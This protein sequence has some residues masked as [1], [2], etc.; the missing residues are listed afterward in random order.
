MT[1]TYLLCKTVQKLP[2]VS[3]SDETSTRV[4]ISALICLSHGCTAATGDL[5][6]A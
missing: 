2:G 6:R 4:I 5:L 3:P 1:E